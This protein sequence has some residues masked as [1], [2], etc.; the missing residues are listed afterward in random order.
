MKKGKEKINKV[1][2]FFVTTEESMHRRLN[3][4]SSIVVMSEKGAKQFSK[5]AN[6]AKSWFKHPQALYL[7]VWSRQAYRIV[8]RKSSGAMELAPCPLIP[9]LDA[10]R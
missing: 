8:S 10:T 9:V 1:Q 3:L 4:V 7:S 6:Q 2:L 5:T